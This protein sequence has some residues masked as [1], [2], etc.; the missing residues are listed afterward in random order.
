MTYADYCLQ[1]EQID[2]FSE[3]ETPGL[4]RH[5]LTPKA[6]QVEKYG[7]VIDNTCILVT[8]EQHIE[9]HR[10][11]NLEFPL[12]ESQEIAYRFMINS[13]GML[14]KHHSQETRK[15]MSEARK[16]KGGG[17]PHS[18]E[19]RKKIS[20]ALKGRVFTEETRRKNSESHK[21]NQYALGCSRSEE[22]RRKLSKAHKGKHLS[23]EHKRKLSEAKKGRSGPNKGKAFSEET[24]KK[25]SESRKGKIWI[26]NGE[27]NRGIHKSEPIPEGW[28][29]GMVRRK[30]K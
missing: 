1:F 5:H 4:E 2:Y 13:E 29:L 21:G 19:H 30:N 12:C 25:M 20:R 24:R 15:K 8:R 3:R 14:G 18:E 10:L 26:N 17:R 6:V 7:R 16:G 23:E 28:K 9:A 27:T 22:T 11:L